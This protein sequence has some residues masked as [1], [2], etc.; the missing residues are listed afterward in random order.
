MAIGIARRILQFTPHSRVFDALRTAIAGL[1]SQGVFACARREEGFGMALLP[2]RPDRIKLGNFE[3]G[4]IKRKVRQMI[5]RASFRHQ[6]REDLEQELLLRLLQALESFDPVMGH[7]KCF[8]TAVVERSVCNILRDARAKKRDG[9]GV[10]SLQ[11]LLDGAN[12]EIN[13]LGQT[14][15]QREYDARRKRQ[16]RCD[17]DLAQLVIDVQSVLDELSDEAR[18][19]A[20]RLK[21][22]SKSQIARETGVPRTTLCDAARRIRKQFEDA[23]LRDYLAE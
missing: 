2:Y 20:N 10:C 12:E 9:R 19:L 8:V 14:I 18:E 22:D 13:F 23:S 5:G 15:S 1:E 17:M 16:P 21:K 11:S 3:H 6:D 7:R 4:I